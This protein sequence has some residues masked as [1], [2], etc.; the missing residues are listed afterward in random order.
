MKSGLK[1]RMVEIIPQ[2]KRKNKNFL[3]NGDSFRH[4]WDNIRSNICI[5]III[6]VL[7]GEDKRKR[8]LKYVFKE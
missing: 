8:T 5:I 3:K 6:G 1:H 2:N 4:L 7:E